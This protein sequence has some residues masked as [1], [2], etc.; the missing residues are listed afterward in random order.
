ME[1]NIVKN[2]AKEFKNIKRGNIIW[3]KLEG[4][5]SVTQ[6]VRPLVV[7]GNNKGNAFSPVIL[8]SPITS[9]VKK[10]LLPTQVFIEGDKSYGLKKD[11][12]IMA[13]QLVT[14][15]KASILDVAGSL[16]YQVMESV[17]KAL[18]ISLAL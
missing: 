5:G 18:K 4:C 13:E 8:C 2:S 11:G 12:V 17:N 15:D 7:V 16:P 3:A 14:V 1:M 6:G 10:K 9:K